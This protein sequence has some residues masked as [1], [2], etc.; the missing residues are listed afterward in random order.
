M[1]IRSVRWYIQTGR[2]CLL[3][4]GRHAVAL[5]RS[6]TARQGKPDGLR[7]GRTVRAKA[8][9]VRP[10][11]GVPICQSGTAVVVFALDMS[12]STYRIMAGVAN[13]YLLPMYLSGT[14]IRGTLKTPNSQL[15]TPISIKLQRPDG[16]D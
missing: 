16:Y 4:L 12:S 15:V 1:H 7:K 9:T 14:I 6:R 11:P 5:V 8:R 3:L 2:L 10:C 13:S